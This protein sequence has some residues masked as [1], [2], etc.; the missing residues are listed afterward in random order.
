MANE[1]PL[2]YTRSLTI[3]GRAY[4]LPT[5][6]GAG[7]DGVPVE[8]TV[9]AGHSTTLTIG[10]PHAKVQGIYFASDQ[11]DVVV[12]LNYAEG[13]DTINLA[14]GVPY[15]WEPVTGGTSPVTS[16]VLSIGI[17]NNGSQAVDSDV[18]GF[19]LLGA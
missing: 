8:T 4:P 14:A 11:A 6:T 18:H 17:N 13:A 9:A 16:D 19:V 12:T 10:F 15:F 5:V 1:I 3:Q 2:R 7:V